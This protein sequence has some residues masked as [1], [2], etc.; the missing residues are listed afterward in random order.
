M[1]KFY[2]TSNTLFVVLLFLNAMLFGQNK[3]VLTEQTLKINAKSDYE[4]LYAL[5]SGDQIVINISE[6]EQKN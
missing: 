4:L 6:Q 2:I 1:Q 3:V 5:N